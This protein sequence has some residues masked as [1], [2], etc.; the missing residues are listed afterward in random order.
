MVTK[1]LDEMEKDIIKSGGSCDLKRILNTCG[2]NLCCAEYN[3]CAECKADSLK[4]IERLKKEAEQKKQVELKYF[5][6]D[7]CWVY[8]QNSVCH[9][10]DVRIE[11]G[12]DKKLSITYTWHNLDESYELSEIWDEGDFKDT[13]IGKT[14]FDTYEDLIKAFPEDYNLLK[15]N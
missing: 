12:S 9:I 3:Y 2:G 8:G 11:R 7:K 13:D 14:V 6:G 4:V 10:D 5:P 15:E 1:L